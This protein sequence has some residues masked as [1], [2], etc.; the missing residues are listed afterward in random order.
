MAQESE[1]G[2]SPDPPR[3]GPP[4]CAT[5]PALA[6]AFAGA[7]QSSGPSSLQPLP[8]PPPQQAVPSPL[9]PHPQTQDSS[10]LSPPT[11]A[12]QAPPLLQHRTMPRRRIHVPKDIRKYKSTFNQL[13]QYTTSIA[14]P[15]DFNFCIEELLQI[16]SDVIHKWMCFKVYGTEEPELD[17]HPLFGASNSLHSWKKHLSNFMAVKKK[18]TRGLGKQSSANRPFE[19]GEFIQVLNILDSLDTFDKKNRF[20]TMLK[21]VFHMLAR[22]DDASHVFKETLKVSSQY[23]WTL[24]AKFRWSKNVR[25]HRNCPHQIVLGAMNSLYCVLL[26]LAIFLKYWI[27]SGEGLTSQWLFCEGIT[28]KESPTKEMDLEADRVKERLYGALKEIFDSSIFVPDPD[29][30]NSQYKLG[31]HSTKKY[32]TA[33]ASRSGTAKDFVDYRARWKSQQIQEEYADTVLPWPNIK[34]HLNFAL[35]AYASTN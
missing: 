28:T 3:L 4:V 33:H 18:E 34:K 10:P 19:P 11:I 27:E 29:A 26:A 6:S 25:E 14:Y 30:A 13:M 16:N 8:P 15:K 20:P 7:L 12:L 23:P 21:N 31:V 17:T 22:G 2:R 35:E 1:G 9:P 24:T 32:G 5:T